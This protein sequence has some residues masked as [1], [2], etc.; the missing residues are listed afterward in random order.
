MVTSS[1]QCNLIGDSVAVGS[2]CALSRDR[3]AAAAGFFFFFFTNPQISLLTE[4]QITPLGE[5]NYQP[6]FS[7]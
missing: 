4:L 3:A 5:D 1:S 7:C 6:A 2:I